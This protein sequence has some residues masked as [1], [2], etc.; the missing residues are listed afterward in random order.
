MVHQI[1]TRSFNIGQ[2]CGIGGGGSGYHAVVAAPT[3]EKVSLRGTRC[4]VVQ[5][6]KAPGIEKVSKLCGSSCEDIAIFGPAFAAFIVRHFGRRNETVYTSNSVLLGDKDVFVY[7][8]QL[9]ASLVF[10]IYG[11]EEINPPFEGL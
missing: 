11:L 7:Y 2:I 4:C 1:P 5:G 6:K 8:H 3:C 9:L 10:D